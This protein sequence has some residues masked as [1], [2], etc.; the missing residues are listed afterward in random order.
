MCDTASFTYCRKL[1]AYKRRLVAFERDVSSPAKFAVNPGE[2]A[3]YAKDNQT[4]KAWLRKFA[5]RSGA[6]LARQAHL[7]KD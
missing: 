2:I 1:T 6:I 7:V 3:N 5:S 4:G